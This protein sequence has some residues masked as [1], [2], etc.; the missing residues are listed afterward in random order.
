MKTAS[1]G[2]DLVAVLEELH[3]RE[4]QGL[5]VEGGAEIA[6]AFLRARLVNKAS[7]FIAPIVLGGDALGAIAGAGALNVKEAA[8]LRDVEIARHAEDV[9]VRGYFDE[10][11]VRSPERAK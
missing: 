8:R 6:G 7:F 1:G 10:T 5:L 4:V 11:A 2:R 3:R 9:E